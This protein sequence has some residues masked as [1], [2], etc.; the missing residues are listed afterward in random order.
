MGFPSSPRGGRVGTTVGSGVWVGVSVGTAVRGTVGSWDW[1]SVGVEGGN[2]VGGGTSVGST[3]GV[4][5]DLHAEK[6]MASEIITTIHRYLTGLI[7][8]L[9]GNELFSWINL[10]LRQ[11]GP[12]ICTNSL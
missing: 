12:G 5:G 8:S 3:V 10:R 11:C 6:V 7:C 2:S 1:V 9:Q 4:A